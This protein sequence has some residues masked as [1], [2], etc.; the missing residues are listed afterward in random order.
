MSLA[1]G[2]AELAG[3][4][5][6]ADAEGGGATAKAE[7]EGLGG[8][9]GIGRR[10]SE[11]QSGEFVYG[12][13][14][15]GDHEDGVGVDLGQVDREGDGSGGRRAAVVG[16][17]DAED[18]LAGGFKIGG[19]VDGDGAA[20]VDGE[21]GVGVA[22]GDVVGEGLADVGI[23]GTDAADRIGG[24]CGLEDGEALVKG[25]G[26]FVEVVHVDGDGRGVAQAG[27]AVV[28]DADSE[29]VAGGEL[30]V[31]EG[32]VGHGDGTGVHVEGEDA[33]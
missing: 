8:K 5:V 10:G 7:G 23:G 4:G 29:D 22:G 30:E 32:V 13:R 11:G 3:A 17:V 20:G 33:A 2:P 25:H 16:D 27:Y 9:V 18:V 26:G 12:A 1:R 21:G 19:V 24:A 15:R 14:T 6:D 31:E 28:D